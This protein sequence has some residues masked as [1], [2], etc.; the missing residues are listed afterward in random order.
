MTR[1]LVGGH[2]AI[3]TLESAEK[4]ALF[5]GPNVGAGD[6]SLA[7]LSKHRAIA[8]R[9]IELIHIKVFLGQSLDT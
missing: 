2:S 7:I 4:V 6:D 9:K 8:E 5:S 1:R 3:N